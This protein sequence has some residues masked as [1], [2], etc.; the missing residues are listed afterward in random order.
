MKIFFWIILGI[1]LIGSFYFIFQDKEQIQ[2]EHSKEN[3]PYTEK[4]DLYYNLDNQSVIYE[5]DSNGNFIKT[6]QGPVPQ[7]YNETCFRETGRTIK[8]GEVC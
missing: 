8:L 6:Y 2:K 5:K 4:V 1:L 7:R 3:I